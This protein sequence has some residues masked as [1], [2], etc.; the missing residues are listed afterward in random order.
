MLIRQCEQSVSVGFR[1]AHRATQFKL[2]L[3]Y[4]SVSKRKVTGSRHRNPCA[5]DPRENPKAGC[6]V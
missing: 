3:I 1:Q 4:T 5:I 6:L 2:K